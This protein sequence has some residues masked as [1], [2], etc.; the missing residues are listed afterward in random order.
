MVLCCPL[1]LT[2]ALQLTW[3]LCTP[4]P[5]PIPPQQRVGKCQLGPSGEISGAHDL[6]GR[7]TFQPFCTAAAGGA[8]HLTRAEARL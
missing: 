8:R 6:V 7:P 3:A 2:A 1:D 4:A 5:S